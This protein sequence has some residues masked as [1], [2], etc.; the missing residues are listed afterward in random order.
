MLK[1][2]LSCNNVI[3]TPHAQAIKDLA[4]SRGFLC[5]PRE[6]RPNGTVKSCRPTLSISDKCERYCDRY[7]HYIPG[8]NLRPQWQLSRR[9]EKGRRR[10]GTMSRKG[11][12]A[13]GACGKKMKPQYKSTF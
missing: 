8:L 10:P 9:Q 1:S 6:P 2:A 13:R 7:A 4:L 3:I 12:D 5:L 11:T